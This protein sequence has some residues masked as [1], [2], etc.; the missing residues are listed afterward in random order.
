M[1]NK[2]IKLQQTHATFFLYVWAKPPALRE[3]HGFLLFT[4]R[5]SYSFLLAFEPSPDPPKSARERARSMGGAS[6]RPD[7]SELCT[8]I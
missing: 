5:G 3:K 6:R 4:A 1:K 7:K 2:T 8:S